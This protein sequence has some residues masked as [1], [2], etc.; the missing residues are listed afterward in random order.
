MQILQVL[1]LTIISGMAKGID[2]AAHEGAL[3]VEGK[4]IA[5]LGNGPKCVFPP[6]NFDIYKRILESGGTIIS[7]YP[8]DTEPESEFF[9]R[10]NRIVSGLS[11]GVLI[12]EA[13]FRSGTSITARFAKEQGRD[14]FCIPSSRE[15]RKGTGCNMLIQKGAK[16]VLEP[17][18]IINKYLE[19][20]EYSQISMEELEEIPKEIF[21]LSNIKEEY[22]EICELLIKNLSINEIGK[23]LGIDLSEVYQKLFLMELE[24]VIETSQGNYV[25]KGV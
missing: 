15:N 19:E 3:D 20:P 10:R 9:R 12:V 4:T 23:E 25:V 21:D 8:G 2:R 13:E 11:M 24:G 5:V 14:V 1:G 17:S 18:E 6:E 16:L 22:R 7:E